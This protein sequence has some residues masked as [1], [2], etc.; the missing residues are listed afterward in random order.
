MDVH[1]D[2]RAG[3]SEHLRQGLVVHSPCRGLAGD[4]EVM[5]AFIDVHHAV[6]LGNPGVIAI[7]IQRY[8]R[9]PR[10]GGEEEVAV[11]PITPTRS[12]CRFRLPGG[13]AS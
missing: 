6:G 2:T 1:R 11:F 10:V 7:G 12:R 3:V 4:G 8:K 5:A 13:P 9:T